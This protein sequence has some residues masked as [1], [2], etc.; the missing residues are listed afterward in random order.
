MNLGKDSERGMPKAAELDS[1]TRL[2]LL[3]KATKY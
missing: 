3:E 1:R 2:V